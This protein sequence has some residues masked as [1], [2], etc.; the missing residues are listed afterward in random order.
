MPIVSVLWGLA[1]LGAAALS[2]LA[3]GTVEYRLAHNALRIMADDA[4]AEAA[5]AR[6]VLGLLDPRPDRRGRA[7]GVPQGFDLGGRR[8]MVAVQDELGRIDLNQADGTLLLSLL[9]SVGV[10]ATAA[11]AL[12]D[13]IL[14]WRD[15]SPL[16]RLNGAKAAEYRAAG[17][18]YQPRNG[19]FQSVDELKLVMGV[20]PEIFARIEAAVTVYSG[21]PRFDPQVAPREALLALPTMDAAQAAALMAARSQTGPGGA[22]LPGGFGDPLTALKGRAFTIVA[23]F[24]ATDRV[25]RRKAAIRISGN[26]Y[27]PYWV[28]NWERR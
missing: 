20:T 21:R 11:E 19:S 22:G 2:L 3:A 1:L 8:I 17:Y 23:Q 5:V 27:Q 25:V 12:V 16:K 7:D 9:V 24:Q 28:L 6:A 4:V 15:T 26:P 13:K 10:D 14:D 18:D